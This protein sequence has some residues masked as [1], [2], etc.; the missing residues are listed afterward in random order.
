MHVT[1]TGWI[2]GEPGGAAP[3]L[4]LTERVLAMR[5]P[6][7]GGVLEA[8]LARSRGAEAREAAREAAAAVDPDERAANLISKGYLPGRASELHAKRGEVAAELEDERAK[9]AKGER[10][11]ARVR[12]M[13]ERGQVGGLAAS[14]MLD[15]DFGDAHRAQQ[16]ELR[17]ARLDRQIAETSELV[18]PPEARARSGV[19]EAASRARRILAEVEQERRAEDAAEAHGRAQL[20]RERSKFYAARGRRPFGSPGAVRSTEHT[21]DDCWVCAEGRRADAAQGGIVSIR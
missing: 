6:R 11:T 14:R 20:G 1:T 2:G 5:Q 21:G 3:D 15:G 9:I 7:A 19:E 16:L 4:P 18:A 17:I 8:A 13:L 10:V 12:G